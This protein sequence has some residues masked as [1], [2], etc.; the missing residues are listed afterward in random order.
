M[1]VVLVCLAAVLAFGC[2]RGG[3]VE[4]EPEP[5]GLKAHDA[6]FGEVPEADV[7][8]VSII[9]KAGA[10][11]AVQEKAML[12]NAT[13]LTLVFTKPASGELLPG[14]YEVWQPMTGL[15]TPGLVVADLTRTD[16][17]CA[18]T[19]APLERA[20]VKGS[21]TLETIRL[22]D[23]GQVTGSYDIVFGGGRLTGSFAASKCGIPEL[24][25]QAEAGCR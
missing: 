17:A 8:V 9:D 12:K 25:E 24:V 14:S 21:V 20:P 13:S 10:C 3:E 18:N 11:E 6:F 22:E 16:D 23:D 2:G 19:L 15:P 4:N 7:V 1:R 5:L